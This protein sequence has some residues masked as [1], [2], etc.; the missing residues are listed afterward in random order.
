[1]EAP[2]VE[3][4]YTPLVFFFQHPA[5][6]AP[7]EWADSDGIISSESYINYGMSCGPCGITTMMH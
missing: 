4:F 5:L 6:A 2:V 1:L 7:E 3:H